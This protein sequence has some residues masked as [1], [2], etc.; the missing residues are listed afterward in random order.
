[1][2]DRL[3][4]PERWVAEV[5]RNTACFSGCVGCCLKSLFLSSFLFPRGL[6]VTAFQF[7]LIPQNQSPKVNC[8][9]MVLY[10]GECRV[11][12]GVWCGVV[13]GVWCVVCGVWCVVWCGVVWCGVVW[14]GVVWCGVVWCGV[15]CVVWHMSHGSPYVCIA[16]TGF[17]IFTPC[18]GRRSLIF[19]SSFRSLSIRRRRTR[20]CGCWKPRARCSTRWRMS[21]P[22]PS[23]PRW[24]SNF[25]LPFLLGFSAKF[26]SKWNNTWT[27]MTKWQKNDKSS[28]ICQFLTRTWERRAFPHLFEP[29]S[30]I[31]RVRLFFP[32]LFYILLTK[33]SVS[34]IIHV[35]LP[36]SFV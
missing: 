14:C 8:R 13:C 32:P 3:K 25:H 23:A 11:W 30:F 33:T 18:P 5:P 10:R 26:Q 9:G 15:W 2:E 36:Y 35:L 22:K 29:F 4:T 12:C 31:H 34:S 24:I 20:H 1:M 17:H 7:I 27:T 19:W 16:G 28:L 6:Q 21:R